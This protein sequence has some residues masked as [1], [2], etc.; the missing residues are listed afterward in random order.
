[1]IPFQ[2]C[3]FLIYVLVFPL[4]AGNQLIPI[5]LRGEVWLVSKF[6][7]SG[8]DLEAASHYILTHSRRCVPPLDQMRSQLQTVC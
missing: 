8:G 7:K 3:Y 2:N 5:F 6:A 4:L 1:M